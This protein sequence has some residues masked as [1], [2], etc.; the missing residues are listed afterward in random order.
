MTWFDPETVWILR[1]PHPPV[2]AFGWKAMIGIPDTELHI[3]PLLDTRSHKIKTPCWCS[4][5]LNEDGN[6][7][8]Q[9]QDHRELYEAGKH[10]H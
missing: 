7:V 8:H 1:D 3:V 5:W 6:H 4:L 9:A 10:P 2:A